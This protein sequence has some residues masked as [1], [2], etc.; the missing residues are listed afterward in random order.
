MLSV[1]KLPEAEQKLHDED[2]RRVKDAIASYNENANLTTETPCIRM[3]QLVYSGFM[4]IDYTELS[5]HIYDE[6]GLKCQIKSSTV[7]HAG[8]QALSIQIRVPQGIRTLYGVLDKYSMFQW[9]F[10]A[11]S[12][13]GMFYSSFKISEIQ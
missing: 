9:L 2:V 10:I 6:T 8:G 1:S 5:K 11:G 7:P 4:D 12:V 13:C 3:T